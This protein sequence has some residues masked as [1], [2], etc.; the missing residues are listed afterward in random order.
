[1]RKVL[2]LIWGE[3]EWKYFFKQDWTGRIALIRFNKFRP[4]R[5]RAT[6]A[7]SVIPGRA[8]GSAQSAAR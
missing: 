8:N 3:W 1:M 6:L 7:N 2:D 4:T 5:K